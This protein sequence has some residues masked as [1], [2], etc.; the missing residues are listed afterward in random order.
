MNSS[1]VSGID[2]PY[3]GDDPLKKLH[4]LGRRLEKFANWY[5]VPFEFQALAGNWESFT[6]RDIDIRKDEVLAVSSH[7]THL[8]HD[9]GVLGAS[10][11]ELLLRRIRSLN[12]K[13]NH[14]K[15]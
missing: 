2:I 5:G 8:V 3:P 14:L 13:V 9:E 12:P 1:A 11:R 15:P 6:A 7:R 10:P 4:G